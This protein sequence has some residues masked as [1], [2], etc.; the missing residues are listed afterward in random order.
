MN[1]LAKID[2]TEK[3]INEREVVSLIEEKFNRLHSENRRLI[4]VN[5]QR[6]EEISALHEALDAAKDRIDIFSTVEENYKKRNLDLLGRI[7]DLNNT[8]NVYMMIA[9]L[10]FVAALIIFVGNVIL[11]LFK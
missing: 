2:Y 11:P 3:D 6:A 4:A 9:F 10:S 1:T 5:N 7:I 8:V